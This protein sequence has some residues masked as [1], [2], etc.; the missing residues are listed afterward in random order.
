MGGR[1]VEEVAEVV[2]G[3]DADGAFFELGNVMNAKT[4]S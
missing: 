4:P 1:V 3:I 2:S